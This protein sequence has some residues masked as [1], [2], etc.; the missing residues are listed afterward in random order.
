MSRT[1]A[2]AP[3]R[4][5]L[6]AAFA[7]AA[8]LVALAAL[9]VGPGRESAVIARPI[10]APATGDGPGFFFA[11]HHH[12]KRD[13]AQVFATAPAD[14]GD[15][16]AAQDGTDV[17]DDTGE[18]LNAAAT[19]DEQEAL[20]QE[21]DDQDAAGDE[22]AEDAD[23][24]TLLDAQGGGHGGHSKGRK[25]RH[26]KAKGTNSVAR[27][28]HIK[29]KKATTVTATVTQ[30]VSPPPETS[31]V[32]T[33]TETSEVPTEGPTQAPTEVPTEAP[34]PTDTEGPAPTDTEGPTPT[35]TEGPTPT[36]TE[37]P[38]PPE[39]TETEAPTTQVPAPTETSEAPSTTTA[40]MAEI[41]MGLKKHGKKGK[42]D[43]KSHKKS[44]KKYGK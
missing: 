29:K 12:V 25:S 37:G 42:H 18:A 8:V 20:D 38:M 15:M 34:A 17:G 10:A 4:R 13:D 41:K 33:P 39:T 19:G 27:K 21:L 22:S 1:L 24:D 5:P 35:D 31:E 40:T 16:E 23:D 28:E 30:T 44:H 3:H 6:L 2:P 14:S 7:A 26:V 9:V 11:A 36:D 43:K 32:P